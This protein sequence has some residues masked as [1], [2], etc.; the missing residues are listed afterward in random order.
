MAD[1]MLGQRR[2][3]GQLQRRYLAVRLAARLYHD[4]ARTSCRNRQWQQHRQQQGQNTTLGPLL[5]PFS[6]YPINYSDETPTYVSVAGD[7]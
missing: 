6:L 5:V 3:S 2:H 7:G 4:T 1:A